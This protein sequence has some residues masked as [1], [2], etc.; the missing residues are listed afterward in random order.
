MIFLAT[1]PIYTYS[2]IHIQYEGIKLLLHMYENEGEEDPASHQ[3]KEQH[4]ETTKI[5]HSLFLAFFLAHLCK[6]VLHLNIHFIQPRRFAKRTAQEEAILLHY[7]IK[8]FLL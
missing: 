5:F 2:Y 8:K 4:E 6:I 1:E 3:K 7:I